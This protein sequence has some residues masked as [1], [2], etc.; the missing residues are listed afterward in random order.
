[1]LSKALFADALS[2]EVQ[3][4]GEELLLRLCVGAWR[5]ERWSKALADSAATIEKRTLRFREREQH[6][7]T[8]AAIRPRDERGGDGGSWRGVSSGNRRMRTSIVRDTSGRLKERL[9][10]FWTL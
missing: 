10:S 8:K 9:R 3:E 5:E 2:A 7:A 1:M 4:A 6:H